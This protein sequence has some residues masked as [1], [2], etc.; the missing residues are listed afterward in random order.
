V[1]FGRL[2]NLFSAFNRDAL[3]NAQSV[4][5]WSFGEKAKR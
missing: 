2:R 4:H 5:D 3:L 1:S